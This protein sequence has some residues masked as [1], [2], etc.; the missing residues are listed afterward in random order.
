MNPLFP[1]YS[2]SYPGP[3]K[4]D[5]ESVAPFLVAGLAFLVI[6]GVLA[7]ASEG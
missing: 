7:A 1:E 2:K 5:R 6:I 4:L 3:K